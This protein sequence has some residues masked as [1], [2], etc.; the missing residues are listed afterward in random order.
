MVTRAPEQRF[1]FS[2]KPK[3]AVRVIRLA[4][5][6]QIIIDGT[7]HGFANEKAITM[8]YGSHE[9]WI[10]RGDLGVEKKQIAVGPETPE[11]IVVE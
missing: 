9:I 8:S 3:S 7:D 1:K 5:P 6:G 2:L 4:N 11:V 10:K